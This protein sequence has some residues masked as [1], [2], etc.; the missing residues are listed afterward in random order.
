MKKRFTLIE[1]L[2][3]IAII[4]I[5][6][7]ILLPALQ[8]ARERSRGSACVNNL[9]QLATVGMTYSND[10][11]SFWPAPNSTGY[12]E[13]YGNC[14]WVNRLCFAKYIPGAY[15][16]NYKSLYAGS[17]GQQ[18]E[19]M[20]CP[21]LTPKKVESSD[22][23]GVNL[24]TYAAIYN[25]NTGST[26]LDKD[27]NWGVWMNSPD[28]NKAYLKTNDSQT[29]DDNLSLA[30]RVWFADGKSYQHGTQYSLIGAS[31]LASDFSQGGKNY[32][33]FHVAHNGRG[34]MATWDGHV[35]SSDSAGMTQYYQILIGGGKR[36]SVALYYY[37]SPEFECV[38]N[39]GPGHLAYNE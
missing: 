18:V 27:K 35:A 10:Y 7:A 31:S 11:R 6:A 16:G 36:R 9:K 12:S 26:S 15:P 34:N 1:L 24:Q 19:W 37:A 13:K 4:A 2:V 38:D 23:V 30:N 32:A 22:Y 14:G 17:L 33:R 3:V 29:V 21:S 39:G 25:N 20:R 8:A 5:L 28:Y